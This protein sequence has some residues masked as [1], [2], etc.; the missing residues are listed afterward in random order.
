MLEPAE[1]TNEAERRRVLARMGIRGPGQDP[2]CQRYARLTRQLLNVP[3][4]TVTIVGPD[5]Q[6]FRGS[7]GLIQEGSPR[8][9][10]FC[11][12]AILQSDVFYIP[13][14]HRDSRFADNPLVIG[15]PNIRF[16]AGCPLFLPGNL[17]VG[18][19]C[20]IDREPRMLTLEEM[21]AL[22]DLAD[23]LQSELSFLMQLSEER[24]RSADLAA[25]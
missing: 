19:L 20:A 25:A 1:P 2:R 22:R 12:H 8:K 7:D 16:Y 24:E 3:I 18:T 15:N 9:V 6:W 14:T 10:S 5:E 4:A 11:A 23:C 21:G 17:G 13:D